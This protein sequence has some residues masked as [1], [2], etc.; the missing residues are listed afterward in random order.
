[1][2]M[3]TS[4]D[5]V[6]GD[7]PEFPYVIEE[8]H[9]FYNVN[10]DDGPMTGIFLDQKEVR[11]KIRDHYSED[12]DILNLFSYTGAFSVAASENAKSTTSVDLANR[13]RTLTEGNFGLNAMDLNNNNI[14]IMDVFDYFK[15]ALRH[16]LSYDFIVIDQPI[17]TRIMNK[18]FSEQNN[19]TKVVE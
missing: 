4:S 10:L 1:K 16:G 15:Y 14:F 12:K 17:V 3:E 19:Y 18:T 2:G 5:F 6:E 11:K 7:A 8:N 13:A 9:L